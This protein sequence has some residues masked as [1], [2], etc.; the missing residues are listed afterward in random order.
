MN[1]TH[2]KFQFIWGTIKFVSQ[3]NNLNNF[4][5]LFAKGGNGAVGAKGRNGQLPFGRTHSEPSH[6]FHNEVCSR[7]QGDIGGRGGNGGGAGCG[8]IGGY[9]GSFIA[10]ET[11][12]Y[13]Y[14]STLR[15][16]AVF[17]SEN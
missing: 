7:S 14:G 3:K 5:S 6:N 12:K 1:F 8:G 11:S 17:L 4:F 10:I 13:Y 15:G 2:F 9:P 16:S